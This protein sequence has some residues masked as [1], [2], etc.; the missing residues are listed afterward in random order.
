MHSS[1]YVQLE[2]LKKGESIHKDGDGATLLANTYDPDI[3]PKN[4]KSNKLRQ[5]QQEIISNL[6]VQFYEV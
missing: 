6:H 1:I 2:S 5:R 4:T 3:D